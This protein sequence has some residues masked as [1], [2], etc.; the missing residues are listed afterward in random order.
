MKQLVETIKVIW[1]EM[2]VL[3]QAQ[4]V[5]WLRREDNTIREGFW[6]GKARFLI[7]PDEHH[8]LREAFTHWAYREDP[9]FS[10]DSEE[11]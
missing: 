4:R 9:S 5:V 10:I 1:H 11:E 7:G 2:D 8:C 3:P 6:N